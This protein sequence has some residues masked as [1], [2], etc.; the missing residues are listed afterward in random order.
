M[1]E[2]ITYVKTPLLGTNENIATLV[3]WMIPDGGEVSAG[4]SVCS[5]ETTKATFDVDAEVDGYIAHLIDVGAE[6][7]VSDCLAMI[8]SDLGILVKEKKKFLDNDAAEKSKHKQKTK[9]NKVTKKAIDLAKKLDLNINDIQIS[10]IIKEK[11]VLAFAEK[12]G[13][14][15]KTEKDKIFEKK[16]LIGNQK[17]GKDLMLFSTNN[18]PSSYIEREMI[19]D[20]LLKKIDLLIQ[21]EGNYVTILSFIICGLAK[22]L[23]H[24]T[25]FNSFREDDKIFF[26]KDV[27]IGVV[28]SH[29]ESISVPIIKNVDKKT[30]IE[31]V[32]SLMSLRKAILKKKSN[33]EDFIDG[34][35]TVS[36]MDHTDITSFVPIIHPKQAAVL[37]IPKIQTKI[38]IDEKGDYTQMKYINLGIS[39]DHSFLDANMANNF[40]S[41]VIYQVECLVKD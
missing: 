25:N 40:L 23:E 36:A 24:N 11:D 34:T 35:F 13:I 2:D 18:I 30:P 16:D 10:G 19:V 6:I 37:A 21:R 26:Y 22:A 32:Q 38:I 27:N 8:H 7:S 33:A 3:E 14:K 1:K 28:V 39:F 12:N 5:L 20:E 41:K 15:Q 17:L 31:V 29:N 4:D 9:L